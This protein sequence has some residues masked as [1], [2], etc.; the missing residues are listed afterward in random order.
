MYRNNTTKKNVIG[1]IGS[2]T[3]TRTDFIRTISRTS[4]L[5]PGGN[6]SSNSTIESSLP[7]KREM[8]DNHGIPN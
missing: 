7:V 3:A 5:R 4:R 1:S 6:A 2:A 8:P